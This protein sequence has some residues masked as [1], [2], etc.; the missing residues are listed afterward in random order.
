MKTRVMHPTF[1]EADEIENDSSTK[2][3][4]L[5]QWQSVLTKRKCPIYKKNGLPIDLLECPIILA[6]RLG[7]LS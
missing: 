1:L 7:G 6:I 4:I 2:S 5:T 3:E